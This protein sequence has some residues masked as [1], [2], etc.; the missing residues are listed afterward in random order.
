MTFPFP[1]PLFC[2]VF[3]VHRSPSGEYRVVAVRDSANRSPPGDTYHRG[4]IVDFVR[5]NNI[6]NPVIAVVPI[7]FSY[8]HQVVCVIAWRNGAPKLHVNPNYRM[9]SNATEGYLKYIRE[10][11]DSVY[12]MVTTAKD[13]SND[14]EGSRVPFPDVF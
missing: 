6:Q 3:A 10:S 7:N 13:L 1:L 2:L 8:T 11:D 5:E 12:M 14:L 9:P 4:L